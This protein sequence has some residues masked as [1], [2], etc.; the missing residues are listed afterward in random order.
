MAFNYTFSESLNDGYFFYVNF[1]ELFSFLFIRTRSSIK[2]FPKFITIVNLMFLFY[3]NSYMYPAQLEA[4]YLLQNVS[5]FFLV[6]FLTHYEYDAINDWNPY[7]S[8]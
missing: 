7:G 6:F 1:M 8:W 5:L 2:Y 3:V 4:L